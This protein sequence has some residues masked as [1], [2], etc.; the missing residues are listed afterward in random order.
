MQRNQELMSLPHC[1]G[2]EKFQ[3]ND[4][5]TMH[6]SEDHKGHNLLRILFESWTLPQV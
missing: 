3:N 6:S 4:A 2:H 1:Q 5:S